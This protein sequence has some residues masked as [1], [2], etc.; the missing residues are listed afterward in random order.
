MALMMR[1]SRSGAMFLDTLAKLILV[2]SLTGPIALRIVLY[3]SIIYYKLYMSNWVSLIFPIHSQKKV[4]YSENIIEK[5]WVCATY[6]WFWSELIQRWKWKDLLT[7]SQRRRRQRWCS[8]D[9]RRSDKGGERNEKAKKK[10]V[11]SELF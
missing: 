3:N 8:Y 7:Q 1:T 6:L 11:R 2:W 5:S 9:R 10:L 4:L